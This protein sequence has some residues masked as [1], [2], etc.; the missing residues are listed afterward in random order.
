MFVSGPDITGSTSPGVHQAL[1]QRIV[2]TEIDHNFVNPV[3]DQHRFQVISAFAERSKWTSNESTFYQSP[4]AVFN[5]YMTWALFLLYIEARI[6]PQE[7]ADVMTF[8]TSQMESSR[9]FHRFGSFARELL[10]LYRERPEGTRVP[11]L[12]PA[13]LEW[14]ARQ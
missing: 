1:L 3:T 9:K 10:R 14:A 13:I 8:T 11:L 2:F 4:I 6:S 7:F 5:E 12:Y